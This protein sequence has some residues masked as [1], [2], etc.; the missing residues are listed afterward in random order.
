MTTTGTKRVI[1]RKTWTRLFA[2]TLALTGAGLASAQVPV[3][4]SGYLVVA[5]QD[6]QQAVAPVALYPDALLAQT[7]VASTYPQVVVAAAEWLRAGGDPAQVDYQPWDD[8]VKGLV[9][10]PDAL[11]LLADNYDWMN[12]LGTAF[13]NQRADTMAAVQSV[14]NRAYSNGELTSNSYQNVVVE[15]R[16]IQIVPANPQVIYV[17]VYQPQVIFEE[18]PVYAESASFISFGAGIEVGTWLR[19]DCDWHDDDVYVGNWG[20]HRPWWEHPDFD[21]GRQVNVYL[22]NRPGRYEGERNVTNVT[23]VRNV[24]HVRNVNN[25]R[26]VNSVTNVNVQQ[27]ARWERDARKPA[28]QEHPSARPVALPQRNVV[29]HSVASK[30]A[31]AV[32][33]PAPAIDHPSVRRQPAMTPPTARPLTEATIKPPTFTATARQAAP[34]VRQQPVASAPRTPAV[35]PAQANR[36]AGSTPVTPGP[37]VRSQPV[38]QPTAAVRPAVQAPVAARDTTRSAPVRQPVAPARVAAQPSRT[39][40]AVSSQRPSV[41][42]ARTMPAAQP[43][44]ASGPSGQSAAHNAPARADSSRGR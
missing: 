15:D 34:A 36:Q 19:H 26:N 1:G 8:S 2:A 38:R 22:N 41:A 23:N 29:S 20:S 3:L 42:P 28:P 4:N 32:R 9:H 37:A 27:S 12:E 39:T 18:R 5:S 40:T 35:H 6:L 7:L 33:T 25:V 10:D 24:T 21:H 11:Y 31:P 13:L 16:V 44:R 43:A 30:A 14:R 17:P